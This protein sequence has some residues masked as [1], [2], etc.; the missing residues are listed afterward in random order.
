[1]LP[2]FHGLPSMTHGQNRSS[3]KPNS[4]YRIKCIRPNRFLQKPYVIFHSSCPA[5]LPN[6]LGTASRSFKLLGAKMKNKLKH[7]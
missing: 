2:L 1:M 4:V 6:P 7:G 5:I 3:N